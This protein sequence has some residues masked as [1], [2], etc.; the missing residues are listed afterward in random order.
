MSLLFQMHIQGNACYPP[1][2]YPLLEDFYCCLRVWG[3]DGNHG[4][5]LPMSSMD[6]YSLLV[7]QAAVL[8]FSTPLPLVETKKRFLMIKPGRERLSEFI[9]TTV[10]KKKCCP[11]CFL[12]IS[13][14]VIDFLKK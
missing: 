12:K 7:G 10:F 1:V 14:A 3:R 2:R 4:S 8:Y 5:V 11:V 13:S 6:I 9:A